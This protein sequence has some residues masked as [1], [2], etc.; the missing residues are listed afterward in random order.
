MLRNAA[1]LEDYVALFRR[2]WRWIAA[3]VLAVTGLVTLFTLTR[4][5]VYESRAEVQILTEENQTTFNIS[6]PDLSFEIP[7]ASLRRQYPQW[8]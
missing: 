6:Q 5:Q 8:N 2:R 3:T 1:D 4:D 7:R